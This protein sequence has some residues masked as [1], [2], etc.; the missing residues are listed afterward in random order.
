MTKLP[1]GLGGQKRDAAFSSLPEYPKNLLEFQRMFPDETAC[2]RYLQ[3]LRWPGGFVCES[4]GTVGEPFRLATRPRVIKCRA[5][6]RETSV[7][8]GTMLH[9]SKTS[10]HVWFWAA[11]LVA[12]QTSGISALELQKQLGLARYETAFQLL[13]KL[14]AAMVRPF[15]D[16]IGLDWPVEMDVTFVGGKHKGG[17]SGTTHKLP[18]VIAVETRRRTLRDPATGKVVERA[19]AGRLRL[20][21]LPNK[22]AS[23]IEAFATQYLAP[24]A[25]ILTD[26]GGEF[27]GLVTR[28][29][30][31][32]P[33][34]MLKRRTRMDSWLPM[35]STVAAN[36]KSWLAGT[37]HGVSPQHLQAYLDEFTFRFNRRFHRAVSFRTLLGLGSIHVGPT[38]RSL[39]DGDQ[40][41]PNTPSSDASCGQTG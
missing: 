34:A 12:T 30:G 40:L 7:T 37:F 39:Y 23:V 35:V 24:G 10:P 5:C 16:P 2:L 17:G 4:C 38:Y 20:Q 41:H 25:V 1:T 18:V 33:L 28:G 36:L 26:G 22:S 6:E 9:G 8:A 13:H 14:R 29:F 21:Q 3:Q 11:Y 31:H 19:L 32:Q 15:R 27:E